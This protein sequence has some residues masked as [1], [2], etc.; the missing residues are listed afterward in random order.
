MWASEALL[1]EP[2]AT[3]IW[4]GNEKS[5]SAMHKDNYE[6]LYCQIRGRKKFTLISPLEVVCVQEQSLPQAKYVPTG[7]VNGDFEMIPESPER[8]V[9]GWPVLD[10]DSRPTGDNW[11]D[12]CKPMQVVLGPTDVSGQNKESSVRS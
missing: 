11:W 8:L 3:N 5:V 10:P 1:R 4:I 2:D 7:N 6:N 9:H 12:L